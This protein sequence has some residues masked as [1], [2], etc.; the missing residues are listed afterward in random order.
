MNTTTTVVGTGVLVA[1]G[2]WANNQP[3]DI[4][5]AI[6]VDGLDDALAIGHEDQVSGRDR[7]RRHD[8]RCLHVP[9]RVHILR[10][11]EMHEGRPRRVAGCGR[12]ELG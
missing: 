1:A 12:V 10:D 6:G 3:L 2:R 5:I 4:R 7:C 9:F 8:G 11:I